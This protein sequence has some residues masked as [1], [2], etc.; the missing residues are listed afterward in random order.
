MSEKKVKP[1]SKP[2][3][4]VIPEVKKPEVAKEEKGLVKELEIIK[5]SLSGEKSAHYQKAAILLSE[6][7]KQVKLGEKDHISD[8]KGAK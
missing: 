3:G 6:V 7:I 2:P 8:P 1:E 4:V 5:D